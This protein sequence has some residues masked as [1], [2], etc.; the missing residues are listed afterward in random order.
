MSPLIESCDSWHLSD[1]ADRW[2]GSI[3]SVAVLRRDLVC[4][5]PLR[6]PTMCLPTDCPSQANLIAKVRGIC[7]SYAEGTI[8]ESAIVDRYV[9]V[10]V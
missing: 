7:D 10:A 4:Y 9:V 1:L 3:V 5:C 2:D 8:P 6:S